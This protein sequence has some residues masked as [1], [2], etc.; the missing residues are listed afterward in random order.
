MMS[1]TL[2]M[3]LIVLAIIFL[4]IVVYNVNKKNLKL[5]YSLIWILAAVIMVIIALVPELIYKIVKYV[6]FETS[7]NF[8]FFFCFIWLIGMNL[9]L[10]VIVSRQSE[11]IKKIIQE[12]SL[13]KSE[14]EKLKNEK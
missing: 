1:N 10:S 4:V 7:S 3:E 5:K 8:I 11:K 13:Y 2:R 6:G 12:L 14:N 9:S